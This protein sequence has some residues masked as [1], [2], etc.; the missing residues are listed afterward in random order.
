MLDFCIGVHQLGLGVDNPVF[1]SEE[2]RKLAHRDV[3]EFVDR[4]ADHLAAMLAEIRGII[5]RATK[6]A[7]AIWSTGDD[8]DSHSAARA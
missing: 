8:Q 7:D 4:E 2:W 1:V 6:Q 5:G 3:A